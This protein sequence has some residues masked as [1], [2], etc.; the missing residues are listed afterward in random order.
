MVI[1]TAASTGSI[2]TH[3][4]NKRYQSDGPLL[5]SA[6]GKLTSE[7]MYAMKMVKRVVRFDALAAEGEI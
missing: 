1:S 7:C 5:F 4:K 6:N 3:I 2:Y